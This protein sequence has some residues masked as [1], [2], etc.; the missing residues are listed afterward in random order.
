MRRAW[1][2]LMCPCTFFC[3][4][5]PRLRSVLEEMQVEGIAGSLGYHLRRP[6]SGQGIE[7]FERVIRRRA[8]EKA[9]AAGDTMIGVDSNFNVANLKGALVG[10]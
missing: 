3:C 2:V 6:G 7:R 10:K 5:W 1:E 9:K 4:K 8:F